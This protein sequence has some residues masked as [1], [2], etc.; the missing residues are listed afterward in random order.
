MTSQ[1]R[2]YDAAIMETGITY[3]PKES[4]PPRQDRFYLEGICAERCSEKVSKLY[5]FA[6]IF[7]HVDDVD[8]CEDFSCVRYSKVAVYLFSIGSA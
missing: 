3:D 1:L 5:Q 4:I 2:K 8:K 7:P 6:K